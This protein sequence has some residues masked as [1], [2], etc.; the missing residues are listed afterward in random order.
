MNQLVFGVCRSRSWVLLN[1]QQCRRHNT[2]QNFK[3]SAAASR[4]AAHYL[5]AF[6]LK[7]NNVQLKV[8]GIVTIIKT[9]ITL[10]LFTATWRLL[11][12]CV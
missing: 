7:R 12:F 4:F 8:A 9:V 11:K 2:R 6:V 1:F 5:T 10:Q 3:H